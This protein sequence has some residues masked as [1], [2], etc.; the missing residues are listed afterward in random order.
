MGVIRICRF[1]RSQLSDTLEPYLLWLT[2]EHRSLIC[3]TVNLEKVYQDYFIRSYAMLLFD[4][5]RYLWQLVVIK[6]SLRLQM[7]YFWLNPLFLSK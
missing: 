2:T 7:N 6:V 3:R 1:H 4:N 5:C